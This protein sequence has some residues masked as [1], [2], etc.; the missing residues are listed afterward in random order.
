MG[1]FELILVSDTFSYYKV[2][3]DIDGSLE[4][5]ANS[6]K[7]DKKKVPYFLASLF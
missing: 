2:N 4:K 5:W 3:Q 6:P 1:H 7:F